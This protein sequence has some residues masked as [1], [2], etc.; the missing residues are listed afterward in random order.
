MTWPRRQA[1]LRMKE[2]EREAER[3]VLRSRPQKEATLQRREGGGHCHKS[4]E[5]RE[6]KRTNGDKR[7][8]GV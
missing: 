7:V 5:S 1:K 6:Q 4:L 8:K 3:T 2:D